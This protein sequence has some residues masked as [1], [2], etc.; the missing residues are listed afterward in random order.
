MTK[1]TTGLIAGGL[2]GA[3]GIAVA[4]SDKRQRRHM[5]KGGRKAIKRAGHLVENVTDMF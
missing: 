2:L 5:L 1:F 3:A 4:M